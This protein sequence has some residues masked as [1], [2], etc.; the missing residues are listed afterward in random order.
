MSEKLLLKEII[1][2]L[3]KLPEKNK[4]EI[5][6]IL[7][8]VHRKL[9]MIVER[10]FGRERDYLNQLEGLQNDILKAPSI[11][12]DT[13]QSITNKRVRE[14][15]LTKGKK[16]FNLIETILDELE[17]EKAKETIGKTE[18]ERE[19]KTENVEEKLIRILSR[20]HRFVKQ[21]KKRQGKSTIPIIK[22]QNEYDVQ[23]LLHALLKLE[24]DDVRAEE[25]TPS[26]AGSNSRMDFLLKNEKI[27]IEVK[28]TS[29]NLKDKELGVQLNDDIAKYQTHPNCK[30]LYCFIYDPQELISNPE[31]LQNDLSKETEEFK[32]KV[33]I[34]PRR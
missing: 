4:D 10:K 25:F 1:D 28:K 18:E 13:P 30:I 26:F 22:V 14:D 32:V 3:T 9:V 29:E 31:A 6:Y 23:D 20:F 21:L 27:V 15:L 33:I 17:I 8:K 19:R 34:N 16:Y 12:A 24:F 11:Y 5:K 7:D 2:D